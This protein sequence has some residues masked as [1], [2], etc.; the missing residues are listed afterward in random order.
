METWITLVVGLGVPGIGALWV[1][2]IGIWKG[3]NEFGALKTVVQ[4]GTL[5]MIELKEE[6]RLTRT[7]MK[8]EVN[9]IHNRIDRHEE[10]IDRLEVDTGG[11]DRGRNYE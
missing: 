5:E 7:D 2:A 4:N 11:T 9:T 3:G 8:S 6:I 10:R 1:L